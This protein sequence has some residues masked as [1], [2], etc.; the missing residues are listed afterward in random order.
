MTEEAYNKN[1]E[2]SA[3]KEDI[4]DRHFNL[5]I[6]KLA[7]TGAS[8]ALGAAA[9]ALLVGTFGIPAVIAGAGIGFF[10]SES[11]AN[12]MTLKERTKLQIDEEMTQSYM[13]GKNHW[14]AGYREEVAEH[15]Y[16]MTGPAATPKVDGPNPHR[17]KGGD[18][19][20]G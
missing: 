15:G 3:M 13:A 17:A 14:G 6:K 10:A 5:R 4:A 16:N 11:V 9:G 19:A 20:I 1:A 8:I 2:L 12:M 7:I 18:K